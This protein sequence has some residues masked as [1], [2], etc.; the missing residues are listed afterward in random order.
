MIGFLIRIIVLMFLLFVLIRF[1]HVNLKKRS[2]KISFVILAIVI[3]EIIPLFVDPVL[4][5]FKSAES[6]YHYACI[7]N[8]S[9]VIEGKRS[10]MVI[11]ADNSNFNLFFC[12]KKMGDINY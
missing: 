5:S 8:V 11:S 7:G 10:A 3:L 2:V 1:F 6:A 9:G 12:A 4:L